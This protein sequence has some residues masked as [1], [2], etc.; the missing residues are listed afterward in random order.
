MAIP[1]LEEKAE[2]KTV[3]E[4]DEY[5]ASLQANSMDALWRASLPRPQVSGSRASYPPFHWQWE[6]IRP[7]M[8]R[9][10]ELVKPGPDA[11]RRVLQLIHP[12]LGAARSASHTL[13]ANVQLVL[14]GEISPTHRHS[15]A[16]IRFI[17]EGS[18]TITIVD[19]EP[20]EMR[21]GDL[22]LTPAGAWHGHI[23][24]GSEP[25]IWMDSLDRPV[26][27]ALRQVHQEPYPHLLQSPTLP[28]GTGLAKFGRGTLMPI[29]QRT[30]TRVSPLMR[31]PWEDTLAALQALTEIS[32]DPY[33][34]V[35]MDYVNPMTGSH[36]LPTIGCRMQM[37]RPG[38]HTK[39]HRHS[40]GSV[41][42][43]FRGSGI[44]IVE[45]REIHWKQGDFF[46]IPPWSWHEHLNNAEYP[47]FVFS[48]NDL[49]IMEALNLF[50]EEEA[51]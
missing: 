44:T 15:I 18:S 2:A 23:N 10:G 6:T 49:P 22:V 12:D 27:V 30:S 26:V 29:G 34:D 31:F 9:A 20:V 51:S 36:V 8:L 42:H 16:A 45:G 4:M 48:A 21:P 46:T 43:V 39:R 24:E 25:S 3:A 5:F 1:V 11:E 37:L 40:Y 32:A 7:A 41:H 13:T 50:A 17:I 38:V 28:I 33:D 14:P 47:A 35:A 19:G